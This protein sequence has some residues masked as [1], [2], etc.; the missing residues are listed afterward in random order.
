M[1]S[2]LL[3]VGLVGLVALVELVE[4]VELVDRGALLALDAMPPS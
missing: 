3:L 1:V 4:R 2:F